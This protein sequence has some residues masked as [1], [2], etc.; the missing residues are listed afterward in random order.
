[1]GSPT[2]RRRTS[3]RWCASIRATARSGADSVGTLNQLVLNAH[4]VER[5]M[6]FGEASDQQ[7]LALSVV[8]TTLGALTEGTP[9]GLLVDPLITVVDINTAPSELDVQNEGFGE[10]LDTRDLVKAM[11]ATAAYEYGGAEGQSPEQL[12]YLLEDGQLISYSGEL[13][14]EVRNEF[15]QWVEAVRARDPQLATAIVHALQAMDDHARN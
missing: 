7:K 1:M 6:D 9:Y 8:G 12:P 14:P 2:V 15:N 5:A 3:P 4:D 11:I 13:S 10:K